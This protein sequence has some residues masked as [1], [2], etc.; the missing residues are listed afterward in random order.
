MSSIT[1]EQSLVIYTSNVMA[2]LQRLGEDTV[3][4]A[5]DRDLVL[6]CWAKPIRTD[7]CAGHVAFRRQRAPFV[8][9]SA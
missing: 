2:T 6:E 1:R 3:L 7:H 4:D 8:A 9:A 5:A